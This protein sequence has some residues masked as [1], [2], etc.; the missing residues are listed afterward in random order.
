MTCNGEKEHWPEA[1]RPFSVLYFDLGFLLLYLFPALW[2]VPFSV[3]SLSFPLV[4]VF[5]FFL[6]VCLFVC[7]F[8]SLEHNCLIKMLPFSL[9]S[10]KS[11]DCMFPSWNFQSAQTVFIVY[12]RKNGERAGL[13]RFL[14]KKLIFPTSS[15]AHI[16]NDKKVSWEHCYW[17]T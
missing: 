16:H 5:C 15:P 8:I 14:E 10:L 17:P 3:F 13:S 2:L 12:G 7:L 4:H 6:F 1:L 11:C 9:M